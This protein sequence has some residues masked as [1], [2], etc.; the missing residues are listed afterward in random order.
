[1]ETTYQSDSP[2]ATEQIA[3]GLAGQLGP[4][5]CLCLIGQLGAG[6][7]AF[8]RGLARGLGVDDPRI[9]SSPTYV[10][11]QEYPCRVPLYHLDVYRMGEPDAELVDLGFEEMLAEGV[12]AMEWAD[13]IEDVLPPG[14][15]EV[16]FAITGPETRQLLVRHVD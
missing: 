10:L 16:R 8:V 9:V 2:E 14:R 7:T 3:A 11:C 15:I 5:S 6:K 4:G 1:M 12:V 13:R